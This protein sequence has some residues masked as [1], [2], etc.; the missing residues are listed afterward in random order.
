MLQSYLER[1]KTTAT[2][3]I[4]RYSQRATQSPMKIEDVFMNP[5]VIK[6]A[7]KLRKKQLAKMQLQAKMQKEVLTSAL[8][9]FA[10][11]D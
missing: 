3:S 1:P 5:E 6:K 2:S 11:S 8:I 10:V 9:K 7:E 4:K